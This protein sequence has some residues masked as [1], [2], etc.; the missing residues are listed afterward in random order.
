M[1]PFNSL[2]QKV[3]PLMVTSTET[4]NVGSS[5][6]EQAS[7]SFFADVVWEG[8]LYRLEV[9]GKCFLKMNLQN[10]FKESIP[11]QSFITFILLR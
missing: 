10:K 3:S 4:L 11:E 5:Q 8:K 9:E 1:N 2:F 7:E 6:P